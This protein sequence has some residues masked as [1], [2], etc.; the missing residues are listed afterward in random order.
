MFSMDELL[1]KKN[2]RLAFEHFRTKKDGRGPDEMYLSQLEEYWKINRE[3]IEGEL[4]RGEYQPGIIKMYETVQGQGKRRSIANMNVTDR[5]ITRLLAQKLKRY[6]EP[7]F[8]QN[9][10][11]Y[12]DGKGT[13]DAVLKAKEYVENDNAFV[14]EIDIKDY[15]DTIPLDSI[16]VLLKEKITD[17][18]VLN[19]IFQYLYCKIDV[20][21]RI[22][23]KMIGLVQGNAISPILSNLYLHS[24]DTYME[25]QGYKWIRFADNI[26]VYGNT[27]E[28]AMKFYSDICSKIRTEYKLEINEKKSGVHEA[29]N[30]QFLGYDFYKENGKIDVRKHRYEPV[31]TY[32]NWHSCALQKVDQEYHILKNGILNKKDY[33][34]LFENDK[35]KYHIPVEVVDQI[36]IYGD[37]L[38]S[39]S[40]LKILGSKNIRLS[41]FDKYGNLLGNYLP[42]GHGK[43]AKTLLKQCE[44]YND[45]DRRIKLAKQMEIAGIHNMRA[46]IRY[47]NKKKQK[48]LDDYVALFGQYIVE[49]NEE[50]SLE[51]LMLVEARARQKYYSSFNMILND[52][53]FSFEKRTKRPPRDALNSLI[54]FGNT[55]LYNQF[56]QIIWKTSLDPRIGVIHAANRRSHSLNL[57]FADVFKPIIVDRVIFTLINCQKIKTNR[58]F[59]TDSNGGVLMNREGK[60]IFIEEFEKKIN[61]KIIIKGKSI[62]YRQLMMEEVM[63]YQ[64][65]IL[66]GGKYKPYKYY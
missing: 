30:K 10:Y 60:K 47:Y 43:D 7:Q 1:S 16:M 12:Q 20:D 49:I 59:E 46:N 22:F 63:Q 4:K 31:S 40:V 3:R 33:A 38:V 42:E 8:L 65:L 62:T 39:P 6:L 13:L 58:H 25:E 52:T 64:K 54:S 45:N 21:N 57:D 61:S 32:Y 34:I 35:G 29:F 19:V 37:V 51:G 56:L 53:D 50:K 24:L 14:A 28:E 11:A 23:N 27:Q 36:N 9:S 55:V 18:A 66:T 2:Q 5:Y 48:A 17:E 15:F 26:Y 41:Y 44:L